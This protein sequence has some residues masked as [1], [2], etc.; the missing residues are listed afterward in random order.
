MLHPYTTNV[1]C[2]SVTFEWQTKETQA[3]IWGAWIGE[4]EKYENFR[5]FIFVFSLVFNCFENRRWDCYWIHWGKSDLVGNHWSALTIAFICKMRWDI[6]LDSRLNTLM[7]V[8]Q[9]ILNTQ[10]R[11]YESR[12]YP[13][14]ISEPATFRIPWECSINRSLHLLASDYSSEFGRAW[15][16]AMAEPLITLSVTSCHITWRLS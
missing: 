13:F 6:I 15:L 11:N 9:L 3:S 12:W 10:H 2:K 4:I 5:A 7:T 1:T 16:T 14:G 8:N